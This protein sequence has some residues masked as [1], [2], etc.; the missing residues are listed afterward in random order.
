LRGLIYAIALC[1]GLAGIAAS[2]IYIRYITPI[3]EYLVM[4]GFVLLALGYPRSES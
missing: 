3:A 1:A 4:G 2:F